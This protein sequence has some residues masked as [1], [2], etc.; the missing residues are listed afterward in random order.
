MNAKTIKLLFV[1]ILPMVASISVTAAPTVELKLMPPQILPGTATS[2]VVDVVN[3][4]STPVN[5]PTFVVMRVSL[6]GGQSFLATTDSSSDATPYVAIPDEF[7]DANDEDRPAFISLAPGQQFTF[8]IPLNDATFFG[9]RRVHAPGVYDVA[10][11]LGSIRSDPVVWSDEVHLLVEEPVGPD[12]AVWE[13]MLEES[14]GTAWSWSDWEGSPLREE[15]WMSHRASKYTAYLVG[16]WNASSPDWEERRKVGLTG[17]QRDF[18]LLEEA[19]EAADRWINVLLDGGS[20]PDAKQSVD[21]ARALLVPLIR[22][23]H[24][25]VSHVASKLL[26]ELPT[27]QQISDFAKTVRTP[28]PRENARI[29]PF[30]DCV[31]VGDGGSYEAWFGYSSGFSHP[32]QISSE[33][34]QNKFE[35][36]PHE[37]RQPSEFLPGTH[38][39]VV[40][41]SSAD[42]EVTWYIRGRKATANLNSPR[43]N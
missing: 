6:A 13:R 32:F 28:T 20:I 9:D 41:V 24:V 11:A 39:R 37:R 19:K 35:P 38:H 3:G 2:V 10:V 23:D 18:I 16:L 1:C 14:G 26:E 12:R 15:A 7:L 25:Y 33:T 31:S 29:E 17:P 40:S 34:G 5:I 22:S 30:L 4:D 36:K 43:C 27:H 21:Q 42:G 8:E